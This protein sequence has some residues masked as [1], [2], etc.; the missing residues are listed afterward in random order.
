MT[1]PDPMA[2]ASAAFARLPD[3][4]EPVRRLAPAE[5]DVDRSAEIVAEHALLPR[6]GLAV[7]AID[8]VAE[9]GSDIEVAVGAELDHLWADAVDGERVHPFSVLA[10]ELL[11]AIV[12]TARDVDVPIGSDVESRGPNEKSFPHRSHALT[13]L[14]VEADHFVAR[15]ARDIEIAQVPGKGFGAAR[16]IGEFADERARLAVVAEDAAR[17][18][19]RDVKVPVRPE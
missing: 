5:S 6:P 2:H 13:A 11:D 8:G 4:M 7:E 10:I 19:A 1:A 3:P 18:A 15:M 17:I 9:I 12:E 16:F 14:P